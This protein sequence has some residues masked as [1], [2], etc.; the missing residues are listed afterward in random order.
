MPLTV[1]WAVTRPRLAGAGTAAAPAIINATVSAS[2]AGA[3]D[4][5]SKTTALQMMLTSVAL[6]ESG[7]VSD[8]TS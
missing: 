2:L 6:G 8:H 3:G 1:L 7:A 5:I 4:G